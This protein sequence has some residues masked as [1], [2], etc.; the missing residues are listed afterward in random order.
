MAKALEVAKFFIE[1]VANNPLEDAMTN[2][3]LNKLLYFAQAASINTL[4]YFIIDEDFEAWKFGPVVPS[5]YEHYKEYGRHGIINEAFDRHA[6]SRKE[7]L[8]LL[9]VL[10]KYSDRSTAS[11]VNESHKPHSPWEASYSKDN[12][13]ISKRQIQSFFSNEVV[14]TFSPQYKEE[15]FVGARDESDVLV[16]PHEISHA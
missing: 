16:L 9:D 13:V 7:Q 14:D 12:K 10:R 1:V 11:L 6:L 2:L 15:D 4:G 8:Y 3:R 5:I